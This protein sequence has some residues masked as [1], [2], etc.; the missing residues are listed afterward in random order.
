MR[1]FLWLGV[2]RTIE[3]PC[4][5]HVKIFLRTIKIFSP[6]IISLLEIFIVKWGL[7]TKLLHWG[8]IISSEHSRVIIRRQPARKYYL[9]RSDWGGE[10]KWCIGKPF[11]IFLMISRQIMSRVCLNTK[12]MSQPS[13]L[14]QSIWFRHIDIVELVLDCES[15]DDFEIE[16]NCYQFDSRVTPVSHTDRLDAIIL[17][18]VMWWHCLANISHVPCCL[19]T[20]KSQTWE[21][22]RAPEF[23]FSELYD[24]PISGG[25]SGIHPDINNWNTETVGLHCDQI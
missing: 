15:L 16:L 7:V 2:N 9:P 8:I 22:V 13:C 14:R 19:S 18:I 12:I 23:Y 25:D 17:N 24:R 21:I 6:L 11:S 3:D 10:W 4:L 1:T 20:I 5:Y